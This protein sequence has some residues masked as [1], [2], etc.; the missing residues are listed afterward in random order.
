MAS[1]ALVGRDVQ[2]LLPIIERGAQ[3]IG[4]IG[5]QPGQHQHVRIARVPAKR[6]L[7]LLQRLRG[8][9]GFEQ[10][11][12]AVESRIACLRHGLSLFRR[13]PG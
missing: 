11:L 10:L 13:L 9:I 4:A 2:R 1:S 7:H 6:A 8:L 12:R 3:L 5:G